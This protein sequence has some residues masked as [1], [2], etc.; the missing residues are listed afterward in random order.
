VGVQ[1]DVRHRLVVHEQTFA[2]RVPDVTLSFSW[3][4]Q[5]FSS[6]GHASTAD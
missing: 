2:S 4:Q 3:H 1:L 6:S 5:A